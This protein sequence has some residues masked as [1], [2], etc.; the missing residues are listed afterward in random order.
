MSLEKN[1]NNF[2]QNNPENLKDR[3][4][5]K[6]YFFKE[7]IE[8]RLIDSYKEVLSS[9][10]FTESQQADFF[11]EISKLPSDQRKSVLALPW[12][13]KMRSLSFAKKEID[14]GKMDIKKLI[15]NITMVAVDKNGFSVG[16]HTSKKDIS[17][18]EKYDPNARGVAR[19]WIA[20]GTEKDHRDS[21]IPMAYFS[22]SYEDIY[23]EKSPKYLYLVAPTKNSARYDGQWGRAAS[24]DIIDKINLQEADQEVEARLKE[25]L[26]NKK[27]ESDKL[28][29]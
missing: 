2:K 26:E 11:K 4:T 29:A 7:L 1:L 25:Y 13:L 3:K 15:R 18:T 5:L 21:D 8:S 19:S 16:Y 28:A 17:P 6:E 9:V 14:K 27:E 12:E 20:K 10:G 24:L 22:K 23:R